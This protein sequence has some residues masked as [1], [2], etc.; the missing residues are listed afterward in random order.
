LI[1]ILRD[2]AIVYAFSF[3][4]GLG[5]FALVVPDYFKQRSLVLLLP[6]GLGLLQLAIVDGYLVATSSPIDRSIYISASIG[7]V[8]LVIGLL[9]SR[10]KL[11]MD[12]AQ[13]FRSAVSVRGATFL[14]LLGVVVLPV[15]AAALP[16]TPY[17]IGIDQV[18]Y[19]ETAQYLVEGG[20]LAKLRATLLTELQTTDLQKAKAQNLKALHFQT[21][22]DSE[23]LLKAFRWGF[24]GTIASLTMLT[25]SDN[26]LRVAFLILVFSYALILGL[27]LHVLRRILN[28][29]PLASFAIVAAIALN[30]NLLNVYFEGQFAQIFALPYFL[31]ILLLWYYGRLRSPEPGAVWPVTP[32]VAV[33]GSLLAFLFA[34]LFCV[35]NESIVLI[36]G[37]FVVTVAIDI[38]LTLRTNLASIAY[39]VGGFAVGALLMIP[40]SA[41]WFYYSFANLSGLS[42]AGFWQPHWASFAEILG[43]LDMYRQ[44]GYKLVDRADINELANVALSVLAV[45]LCVRFIARRRAIDRSF[46]LAPLA[47]IAAAYY[48]MRVLDDIPNYPYMKIYTMLVPLVACI[49]LSE[50]YWYAS[51]KGRVALWSQYLVTAAIALTG[52]AYVGQYLGQYHY[53]TRDMFALYQSGERRFDRFATY[54]P[55][56]SSST[57]GFISRGAPSIGD[58]M[59]TPLVSL[60]WVNEADEKFVAPYLDRPVAVLLQNSDLTC[61]DCF[62]KK[63]ADRIAYQNDSYVLFDSGK[64]LK[65]FCVKQAAG[66]QIDALG[67]DSTEIRWPGLPYPQCDYFYG[68]ELPYVVPY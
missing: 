30:C 55:F 56:H 19:T 36:V 43:L 6:P 21:Y 7:A 65:D 3:L 59:L 28:V 14:L 61:R 31:L 50:L 1:D 15:I 39:T 9:R 18:G 53:V 49:V 42:R 13:A 26:A 48:K 60:N 8:T 37:F 5:I 44:T 24:P 63:F 16:T 20:T 38:A 46:W 32:R 25:R 10:G 67:L 52:I 11:L 33:S 47:I 58:F 27:S 51:S 62:T 41:Q 34:G 22:V 40:V 4:T 17:R 66:Y 2:L 57:A 23:Y 35:Y 45:A 64:K 68:N 29:P 12:C 54:I